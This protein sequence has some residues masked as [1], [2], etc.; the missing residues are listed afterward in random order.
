MAPCRLN[1]PNAVCLSTEAFRACVASTGLRE[2]ILLEFNRKNFHE[3]RW[4]EMW[5]AGTPEERKTM[6]TLMFK[7]VK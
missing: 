3:M 1:V 7:L 6:A 5:D 4:E 2:R